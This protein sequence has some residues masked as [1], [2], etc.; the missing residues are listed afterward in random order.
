MW[1]FFKCPTNDNNS[2]LYSFTLS[3][4]R[5]KYLIRIDASGEDVMGFVQK[6]NE[7]VRTFIV[8]N[9]ATYFNKDTRYSLGLFS[10]GPRDL[11]LGYIGI[12]E[13]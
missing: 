6:D 13:V 9:M 7:E 10:I 1:Q 8:N 2:L 5:G 3:T 12:R 4:D 11:S